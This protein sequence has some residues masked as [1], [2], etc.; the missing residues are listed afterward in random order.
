M[1]TTLQVAVEQDACWQDLAADNFWLYDQQCPS[2]T[3]L[4]ANLNKKKSSWLLAL[5][6]E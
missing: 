4:Q 5:A 3:T 1:L 2:T 6:A